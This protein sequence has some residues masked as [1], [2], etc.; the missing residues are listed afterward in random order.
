MIMIVAV[1]VGGGGGDDVTMIHTAV[2][3]RCE[4]IFCH[5]IPFFA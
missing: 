3:S 4:I 5:V 1:V 2:I